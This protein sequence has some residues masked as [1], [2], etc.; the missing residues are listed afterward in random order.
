MS[1]CPKSDT[2]KVALYRGA[3][4]WRE[5]LKI[6]SITARIGSKKF[7]KVCHVNIEEKG[8]KNRPLRNARW[9]RQ[10]SRFGATKLDTLPPIVEVRVQQLKKVRL[11]T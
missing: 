7:V 4:S 1:R 8:S 3:N 11:N 2:V 9:N 10:P 6:V 5:K